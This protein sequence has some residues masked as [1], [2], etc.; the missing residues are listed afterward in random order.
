MERERLSPLNYQ[1]LHVDVQ[2][3]DLLALQGA[4]ETLKS[5]KFVETEVSSVELYKGS[6][7]EEQVTGFLQDHGFRLTLRDT[8]LP[9]AGGSW[10]ENL[11]ERF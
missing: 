8:F 9:V 3:A 10:T 2:G 4:T 1:K 7:F 11:Y 5:I 6:C